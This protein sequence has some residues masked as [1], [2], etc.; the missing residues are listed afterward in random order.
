MNIDTLK[1]RDGTYRKA[2]VSDIKR[3]LSAEHVTHIQT[4]RGTIA[5]R[6]GERMIAIGGVPERGWT[7]D[8]A[9]AGTT[10]RSQSKFFRRGEQVRLIRAVILF[11]NG[12]LHQFEAG[13]D[14]VV[15][16]NQ[17][18]RDAYVLAVRGEQV[19]VEYEM[20]AGTSSLVLM[21]A[22]GNQLTRIKTIPHRTL[23]QDW[24]NA[25]HE[26]GYAHLWIGRG[27]R[28]PAHTFFPLP[29]HS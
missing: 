6:P 18:D 11:L 28:M 2:T 13:H 29:A 20:P 10:D 14:T 7:V 25:I 19:L 23:R 17:A 8:R 24:V 22:C 3:M 12:S 27:Q 26:Q 4:E 15:Y 9:V 21:A 5:I 16:A 1:R